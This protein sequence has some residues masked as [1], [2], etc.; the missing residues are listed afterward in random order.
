[1]SLLHKAFT[2][3]RSPLYMRVNHFFALLTLVSVL[4]IA[5]ETVTALE[6]YLLLFLVVEWVT[7]AFF[8]LEYIGR[9]IA[10][11]KKLSYVFSF[12]GLVDLVAIL[13]TYFGLTNLTFLKAAR[14]TRIL[15]FLRMLRLAKVLRV[16][17]ESAATRKKDERAVHRLTVQIYFLT[18]TMAVLTFGTLIYLVEGD[19]PAFA[20]IPLGMLWA[21]DLILGGGSQALPDTYWGEVISVAIRFVGLLLFGLL[22]HIVGKSVQRVLFGTDKGV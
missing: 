2:D 19:N 7:V 11:K 17:T 6:P 21:I 5:L 20:N 15:R 1:M 13:P 22:I 16:Q 10:E 14:V 3:I 12:Y 18:L 8:T 9:L 4:F